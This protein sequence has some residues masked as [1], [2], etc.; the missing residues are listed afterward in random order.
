[1]ESC[2]CDHKLIFMPYCDVHVINVHVHVV[3]P[4]HVKVQYTGHG[5]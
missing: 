4:S 1:M 3:T 5:Y 2:I